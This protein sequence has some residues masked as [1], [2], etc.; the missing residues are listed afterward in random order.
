MSKRL[1]ARIRSDVR[2]GVAGGPWA[3]RA[4][5]LVPAAGCGAAL[6]RSPAMEE[7][8]VSDAAGPAVPRS[9]GAPAD[10]GAGGGLGM[11]GRPV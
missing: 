2:A 5:L 8:K 6:P 10:S 9:R 3:V 11:P 7:Q 1:H 4:A